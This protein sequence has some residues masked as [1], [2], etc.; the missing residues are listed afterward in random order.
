M[1]KELQTLKPP[2]YPWIGKKPFY[3]WI[4]VIIG[5]V[6]QFFQGISSQGFTTYMGPLENQFGWSK[7][8]LSG[9][10]SV[11][12]VEGAITG[13][14]EGFLVD[15]FGPR[16]VAASGIVVM[17]LGFM[18]FGMM[19]S[20]FMFYLSSI[21]ITLG[22]GFQ[23]LLVL[24]VT[25]NN[26]FNRK[27]SIAN[28][29]MGMGYSMAGVIG[30]PALVFIQ[31][32]MNWQASA[33]IT[34]GVIWAIGLPFVLF[35]KE[36]PETVGDVPDGRILRQ[37]ETGKEVL[38]EE[39]D[40]TLN[41]AF[42]NRAFWLLVFASAIGNL[43]ILAGQ[44]HLFP[45]LEEGVGLTRET[46]ALVWTVA[47][48]SNIPAR[49]LG[50]YFG[51][52]M[53]KHIMIGV[54]MVLMAAATYILAIAETAAM[55]FVFAVIFGIGWGMRTPILN[56]IQGEYFG[57][58]SQGVIRGWLNTLGMPLIIAAP[59]VTGYMFDVQGTY[60]YAFTIMAG[61]VGG[62]SILAFIATHP[63][64][65]TGKDRLPVE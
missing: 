62:G 3:G 8:A 20:Y 21:V 9:P 30:I 56:A 17:G 24:S 7:A 36:G 27:R 29:L 39:Y 2:R 57:R 13:P 15:R 6:T 59:I 63:G 35:L 42:K 26:W 32:H 52:R 33:F 25:V 46:A 28:S 50:G 65:Q 54:S 49:L 18:L 61:I 60:E 5:A 14:L 38:A 58:K 64:P 44:T 34:A 22:T 19:D 48:I 43:G 16:K 4:I 40:F 11:S 12:M 41:Q 1:D 37:E 10:R 31:T 23:G 51:D 55:A 53:P 45:H 47:S